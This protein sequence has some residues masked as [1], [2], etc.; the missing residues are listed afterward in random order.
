[1]N[2]DPR[3]AVPR[4]DAVLADP[5]LAT[6]VATTHP[7]RALALVRRALQ[8]VREGRLDP[9]AVPAHVAQAA[10]PAARRVVNATGVVVHTNLGRA[11]LSRAATEA[12]SSA[13]GWTPVELDLSTGRRGPRG[14]GVRAALLDRVP[15]AEAALVL[16]N[17]AAA[18]LLAV[19][20]LAAGREVIVSRGELVE[21][22]DGFRLPELLTTTGARLREVGTTNRTSVADYRSAV[23]PQT[24]AI[25]KVHPSNFVVS[26]FTA[27]VPVGELA[28]LGVPVVCDVGSGLLAPHSLLP[29]EPDVG[30]ALSAGAAVVTCSGDKLLGG[31][32]AGLALGTATVVEAMRRHPLARALRPGK[33]TLAALEAT[34]TEAAPPVEMMIRAD[35]A[36]LHSR[37]SEI[38]RS[39]GTL[40]GLSVEVAPCDGVVGGGG[41]PGVRLPGW[42]LAI[43]E[44]AVAALRADDP[45]VVGRVRNGRGLLDLRTVDPAEDGLLV[46]ALRRL[47]SAPGGRSAGNPGP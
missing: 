27:S 26:G 36:D 15:A 6:L 35:P 34:L 33:L 42:G 31:P 30:S 12:V 29:E 5:A 19:T 8:E 17:G 46:A 9:D 23:G 28:G 18:V 47:A 14:A 1:V 45:A 16:G 44:D 24:G 43:P 11:P 25:L 13:A 20:A 40:P 7:D 32:Q 41:A 38:V 2:P 39:L 21:I 37:A 10:R 4:V 22:G 3:R